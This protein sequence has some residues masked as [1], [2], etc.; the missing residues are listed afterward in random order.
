MGRYTI[1]MD[2][3][4]D[5][6]IK[7]Y[8]KLN[9]ISLRSVAIKKCIEEATDS[10]DMHLFLSEING[11]LNRLLY[12]ENITKKLLEQIY[13]NMGFPVNE[14]LDNNILLHEFYDKNFKKYGDFD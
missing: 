13:I 14:E 2:N 6:K 3:N 4:L 1:E 5:Q 11:K 9:K 8:M 10:N 12:R 7:K